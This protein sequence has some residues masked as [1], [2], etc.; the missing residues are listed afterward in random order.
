MLTCA[1]IGHPNAGKTTLFNSLTGLNEDVGNWHGVT[2]KAKTA[3]FNAC[4][5][6]YLAVDLPGFYSLSLA[7]GEEIVTKEFLLSKKYNAI[8]FVVEAKKVK[9]AEKLILDIK[10]LNKNTVVFVNGYTEFERNGGKID[11]EKMKN[12]LGVDMVYGNVFDKKCVDKLLQVLQSQKSTF[13]P[14]KSQEYFFPPKRRK[15]VQDLFFNRVVA[16]P[17][18][19]ASMVFTFWF[20]F[21][22]FSPISFISALISLL[23]DKI[24]IKIL[25]FAIGSL[26][27]PF[28]FGLI[29]DG[30]LQGVVS[31]L[32]F[33]PQICA[34]TLC[35]NFLNQSGFF[36]R[37]SAVSDDCLSKFGLSGRALYTL[38]SGF[39][40][41]AV[42]VTSS[43]GISNEKMRKRVALSLPVVSCSAK[44]PVY[45]FLAK[46]M[47]ND[48]CFLIISAI[49]FLSIIIPLLNCIMLN[50]TLLKGE[51]E[52][53]TS[54]IADMRIPA[55]KPLLKSLQKTAIQFI[56][57]VGTV[58]LISSAFVWIFKSVS[59]DFRFLS[60]G[61]IEESILCKV[62]KFF[63]F[64][65]YPIGIENWRYAVGAIVGIFAKEGVVSTLSLLLS[66][67]DFIT[68]QSKIAFIVFCYSYTPC[69]SALGVYKKEFGLKFALFCAVYWLIGGFLL[70]Y[71]TYFVLN[72]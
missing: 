57:K 13:I 16:L 24:I 15:K 3:T 50:K 18:F 28:L 7:E 25:N 17:V 46:E 40:C 6:D 14:I 59:F 2:V 64:L 36:S 43:S 39:G 37:F 55:F 19:I 4:G 56:I 71:L 42:A 35:M 12:S 31:V 60:D 51:V 1:I 22:K 11:F 66:P 49:Y 10:K 33:L 53:Y 41:T 54:E 47:F 27:S 45:T 21:G 8:I 23:F 34:L 69:V 30:I 72:L 32:M 9:R 58:I 61:E 20:C 48:D 65:F 70:S 44:M 63:A 67:A 62:G 52:N 29:F 38:V 68:F 5:Q 26:L